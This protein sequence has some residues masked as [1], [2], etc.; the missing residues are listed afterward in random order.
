MREIKLPPLRKPVLSELPKDDAAFELTASTPSLK[1]SKPKTVFRK[2]R[3][4][5]V[6][7]PKRFV[8][9]L[10]FRYDDKTKEALSYLLEEGS[11]SAAALIR[12]LVRREFIRLQKKSAKKFSV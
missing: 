3:Q 1:D 9:A 12:V 8:Y 6:M 2:K 5:R 7:K 11:G 10:K 4:Y